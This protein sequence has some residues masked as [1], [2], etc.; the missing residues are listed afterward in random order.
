MERTMM[1]YKLLMNTAIL[2]R[3][4]DVEKAERKHIVG[5]YDQPDPKTSNAQTVETAVLMTG[6]L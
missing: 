1:D 5:R 4:N 2:C 6:I 3:G